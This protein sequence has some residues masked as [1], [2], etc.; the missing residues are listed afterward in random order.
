MY[1]ELLH[2]W[3]PISI[4][5]FGLL[6]ALGLIVFTY[7]LYKHPLRKRFMSDEQLYNG[8]FL[9]IIAALVGGRLLYV[10]QNSQTMQDLGA[11][12]ALWQGGLSILGGIISCFSAIIFYLIM[13]RIPVIA[14]LDVVALYVPIIQTFGR[15]GCFCA[16]CCHGI[17]CE[18]WYAITYTDPSSCAPLNRPLHP[19][20]L[21]SAGFFL[22]LFGLLLIFSRRQI[23]QGTIITSY[24]VLSSF[25]RFILDFWRTDR[26]FI[27]RQFFD[28]FSLHQWIA[29]FI[30]VISLSTYLI[31]HAIKQSSIS[32]ESI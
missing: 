16:G 26:E 13:L 31:Y 21:Y 1:R 23:P 32:H 22:L 24:L 8:L 5:N 9:G 14:F 29:L 30:V 19:T 10:I 4:N 18:A 15:L 12:F 17:P 27:G 3:G 11:I 20:Q 25:E 2:I 28:I 7:L 6:I